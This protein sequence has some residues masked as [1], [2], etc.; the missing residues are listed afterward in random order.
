MPKFPD[1]WAK[2]E[3]WRYQGPFTRLNRFRGSL[4]GFGT[5]VVA[6]AL[7]NAYE[8]ATASPDHGHGHH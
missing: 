3:A 1:P 8:Y 5:A 7:F 4:P 6:F 2:Q